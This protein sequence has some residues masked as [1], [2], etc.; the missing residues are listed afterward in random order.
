MLIK[1]TSVLLTCA[2]KDQ[3]LLP[4]VLQRLS[5]YGRG[6]GRILV[7]SPVPP[8]PFSGVKVDWLHDDRLPLKK[9]WL[10]PY[11]GADAALGW[12]WQQLVKLLALD[13]WPH[14]GEKLLVW[15]SESVLLRPLRFEDSQGRAWLHPASEVHAAYT[16][17]QQRLLP[18]LRRRY[19][20][21]S[22]ITHWMLLDR[23]ILN[24]LIDRVEDHWRMPFWQAFLAAV[25]SQWRVQG[26]ASEY[27][28][29]FN[30]ALQYHSARVRIRSL[31]WC[32]SGEV[33]Q[34]ES[35]RTCFQYVT[36][37]R[38]LRDQAAAAIYYRQ[39]CEKCEGVLP[40]NMV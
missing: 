8:P 35:M 10:V 14:L 40:E 12:W 21:L 19:A 18:G 32:V 17:H 29:Y 27:D 39:W 20:N 9:D 38:H 24:D 33:A 7:V 4:V 2:A 1:T 28:L 23:F 5:R 31:P 15:D 37:H 36:L 13:W 16:D 11:L 26:G 6:L 3:E 22:G 34:I 30:Y 25:D